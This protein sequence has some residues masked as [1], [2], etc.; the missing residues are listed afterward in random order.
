MPFDL[1]LLYTTDEN[2]MIRPWTAE[3]KKVI[4]Q[5]RK[6]GKDDS[7]ITGWMKK[8]RKTNQIPPV[9]QRSRPMATKKVGKKKVVKK[10]AA[11]KKKAVKKVAGRKPAKKA[12][13]KTGGFQCGDKLTAVKGK[14]DEFYKKFPRYAAYQL[15]C[16]KGSM[17]TSNFVAAVEKLDGVKSRNQA[18]GILT[19]LLDKGCAKASG[20]TKAA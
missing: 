7:Y 19:K 2:N 13:R 20:K 14:D 15:L 12:G 4:A 18:L 3:E 17:P 16:K 5:L 11:G 9:A 6:A 10:K 8:G 1:L